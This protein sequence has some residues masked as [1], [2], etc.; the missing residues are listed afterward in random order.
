MKTNE[1]VNLK[2]T[3]QH[4][5]VFVKNEIVPLSGISGLPS[6]RGLDRVIISAGEIVNVVSNSY[7]HLPNQKFFAEVERKLFESGVACHRQ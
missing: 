1:S 4:D 6:R 5:N 2:T 7:G 3:L